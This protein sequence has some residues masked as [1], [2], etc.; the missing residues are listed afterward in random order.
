MAAKE[1][2][3]KHL[4]RNGSHMQDLFAFQYASEMICTKHMTKD[5][6]DPTTKDPTK[7]LGRT[8]DPA[9]VLTM[10]IPDLEYVRGFFVAYEI[11][12]FEAINDPRLGGNAGFTIR[13]RP[14]ETYEDVLN[15]L[16]KLTRPGLI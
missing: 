3:Q 4:I 8:F 5:P 6:N 7:H 14:N 2:W 13:A 16:K 12:P 15:Q 11:P 1:A 9:T 10:P